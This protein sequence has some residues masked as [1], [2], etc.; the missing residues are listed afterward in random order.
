MNLNWRN[1]LLIF[2]PVVFVSVADLTIKSYVLNHPDM[3]HWLFFD[4]TP[5]ANKGIIGGYFSEAAR[6]IYQI[7]MVALGFFLL[8]LLY[9]IQ[10][11]APLRSTAMRLAISMFF[12]GIFANVCDRFMH[13]YV[14]DYVPA[15]FLTLNLADVIQYICIAVIF[16]LQFRPSTFD[17][18]IGKNLWVSPKFQRRYSLQLLTVG[19]FLVL[20]FGVLSYSFIRVV[21]SELSVVTPI[22]SQFLQAYM[23]F[24]VSISIT[25]LVF[26]FLVGKALSAY[27]AKPMLNFEHYLRSLARGDYNVFHVDEP[28]F[29]YLEDLSDKVRDHMVE[30]HEEL[31]Q[32]RVRKQPRD[33]T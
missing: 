1:A 24:F 19:F 4:I 26:L 23:V 30:I 31:R 15:G 33:K 11:F 21:L 7:P 22:K 14:V 17:E 10:L 13:G 8:V 25:F 3:H 12:G 28:E 5:L 2:A 16:V 18:E 9:F 20:V 29:N 6:P 27:V 32:L